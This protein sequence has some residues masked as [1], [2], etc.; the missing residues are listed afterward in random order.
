MPS[1]RSPKKRQSSNAA[2]VFWPV[3]R[4]T[5]SAKNTDHATNQ[6][7]ASHRFPTPSLD[8]PDPSS[9]PMMDFFVV[10]FSVLGWNSKGFHSLSEANKYADR[11][12]ANDQTC[13]V[14]VA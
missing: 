12:R 14:E 3:S 11:C 13:Y 6:A 5:A 7:A 10:S 2:Q 4:G 8:V 1:N 9:V